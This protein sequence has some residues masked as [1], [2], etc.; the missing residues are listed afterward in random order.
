MK[1][2]YLL[3]AFLPIQIFNIYAQ[4]VF[5]LPNQETP[6]LLE[7][8]YVN[9][10]FTDSLISSFSIWIKDSVKAHIHKRHSEQVYV[11]EGEGKMTIG[12]DTNNIKRGDLLYIPTNTI[13]ALKVTSKTPMKVISFQAPEFINEDRYFINK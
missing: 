2:T 6:D 1:K 13:H 11:I 8:I 5:H 7:N 10:L 12:K 4:K 9:K 3:L